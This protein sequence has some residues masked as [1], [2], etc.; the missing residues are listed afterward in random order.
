MRQLT[1]VVGRSTQRKKTVQNSFI[2][3]IFWRCCM[4]GS[5]S[6]SSSYT[7]QLYLKKRYYHG[8]IRVQHQQHC[9]STMYNFHN[10]GLI[11]ALFASKAKINVVGIFLN[12]RCPKG[13]RSEKK[14]QTTL[15]LVFEVIVQLPKPLFLT[16]SSE[17][18][19]TKITHSE[20]V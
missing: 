3:L 5:H 19:I 18:K 14:F 4:L 8:L 15:I 1:A 20:E 16:F 9:S 11:F 2:C 13:T 6:V 12:G 10:F 17:T 7:A